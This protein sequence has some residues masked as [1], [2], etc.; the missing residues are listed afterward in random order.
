MYRVHFTGDAR[1]YILTLKQHPPGM[2]I[3]YEQGMQWRVVDM[4]KMNGDQW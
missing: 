1:E 2:V 4:G 3:L